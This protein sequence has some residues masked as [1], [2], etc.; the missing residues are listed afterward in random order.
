MMKKTYKMK[1]NW[2]NHLNYLEELKENPEKEEVIEKLKSSFYTS[3][4]R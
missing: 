4:F 2:L 1:N 3:L